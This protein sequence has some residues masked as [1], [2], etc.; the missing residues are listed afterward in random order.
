M[1]TL[2]LSAMC[3]TLSFSIGVHTAGDVQPIELI[4]AG[5]GIV[6]GDMNGDGVVTIQDA[7]EILEIAQGYKTATP[8]QLRSDPNG[9]GSIT[10]DDA[11]RILNII[12][13]R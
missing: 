13:V 11:I 7:I 1:Y 3:L 10:V 8:D 6:E 2:T 12:S 9:N 4:V 5:D